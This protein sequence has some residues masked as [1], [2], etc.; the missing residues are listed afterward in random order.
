MK[1]APLIKIDRAESVKAQKSQPQKSIQI[2]QK[3]LNIDI[4]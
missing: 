2:L 4:N 1:E 3:Y